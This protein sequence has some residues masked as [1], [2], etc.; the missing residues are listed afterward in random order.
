MHIRDHFNDEPDSID[1][2]FSHEK[3][4]LSNNPVEHVRIHENIIFHQELQRALEQL[5]LSC[6]IHSNFNDIIKVSNE[7][8]GNMEELVRIS[9]KF[10]EIKTSINNDNQVFEVV[11]TSLHNTNKPIVEIIKTPVKIIAKPIPIMTEEKLR[12]LSEITEILKSVN[13]QLDLIFEKSE[14]E[15]CTLPSYSNPASKYFSSSRYDYS[16]ATTVEE[17]Y[18]QSSLLN[19][20]FMNDVYSKERTE[21]YKPQ[22]TSNSRPPVEYVPIISHKAP[23]AKKSNSKKRRASRSKSKNKTDDVQINKINKEN[24]HMNMQTASSHINSV[25]FEGNSNVCFFL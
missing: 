17:F 16:P 2:H 14:K 19:N 5:D 1:L 25:Q 3:L 21:F 9:N 22:I 10:E 12:K 6:S 8:I 24:S 20:E 15:N 13:T 18:P 23:T 11:N 4:K 7:R